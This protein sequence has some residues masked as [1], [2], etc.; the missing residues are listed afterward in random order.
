MRQI[1]FFI[2]LSLITVVVK[3]QDIDSQKR[4]IFLTV[5]AKRERP[6]SNILVRSLSNTEAGVTDRSGLFVFADMSDNDTISIML[7]RLGETLIP[8]ASMDSIVVKLRSARRYYYVS[9]VGQSEIFNRRSDNFNRIKTEP[10]DLLDVQALLQ[11]HP[12]RSLVDLLQGN[13]AGL[14][15]TTTNGSFG[16]VSAN[17]RGVS[18]LLSSSE[19][20]VVLNGMPIGTLNDANSI[21][22]LHD[23]T[24]IEVQKSASEWGS[25][26]AN[27]VILIQTK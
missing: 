27:G 19:P 17:I 11:Q 16:S 6:M 22:D 25:R 23:I 2:L 12:Y 24:T 15:I 10:A 5:L 20:L 1:V 14:N 26:G 13:V 9:N 8:V 21:I 3:A 18:S 4:S 7:P